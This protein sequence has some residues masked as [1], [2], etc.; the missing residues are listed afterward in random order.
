MAID[1][2]D[3]PARNNSRTGRM[4][5]KGN[6]RYNPSVVKEEN[7]NA[8]QGVKQSTNPSAQATKSTSSSKSVRTTK[9]VSPRKPSMP[10]K[11]GAKNK[12]KA[13]GPKTQSMGMQY[14]RGTRPK[15][16]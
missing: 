3:A 1:R 6:F 2:R 12:M 7:K 14:S 4:A 11:N 8:R 15:G 10:V 9:S 13:Q 5:A 16:K